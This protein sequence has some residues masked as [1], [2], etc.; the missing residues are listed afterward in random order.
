MI[1]EQFYTKCLAQGAYYIESAG[2]AAIIDPLRE[3]YT[4]LER[5]KQ[6]NTSL[7]YIFETHFHADFVSGHLEL[8]SITKAPIVYGEVANPNFEVIKATDEQIFSI[9]KI[10]IKVLFTPGHTLESCCYLLIN[11]EDK[12]YCVFTGDTLFIGDVGRP[13]LAQK[14][15]EITSEMLAGKLYDSLRN[16]LMTLPDDVI[17]YP[18]HGAGSA[19]GKNMSTETSSTIGVQ[20]KLNYAFNPNLTKSEFIEAVLH[21]LNA[22]P[23]YFKMN[24]DLNKNGYEFVDKLLATNKIPLSAS[25]F[26]Q[27]SLDQNIIILDTRDGEEFAQSHIPNSINIGING[28]FAPW[29]GTI[30]IDVNTPLLLVGKEDM[31]DEVII[32]LSRVG[33]DNVLGYLEGGIAAW[34]DAGFQISSISRNNP[35]FL[36]ENDLNNYQILDVRKKTEFDVGHLNKS[37][38]VPLADIQKWKNTL[39]KNKS[40]IVHCAGGYRSMLASSILQQNGYHIGSEIRGGF[41]A[42]SEQFPNNNLIVKEL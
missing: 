11:E 29:V 18:A 24:V 32:R 20:K 39:D 2:E 19:C 41:K 31:I 13:D 14:G 33:F 15:V 30:L 7:K 37:I 4:Y 26:K 12:P 28:D 27:K 16:K 10:K 35:S 1:V 34:I 3:P 5:L 9:G 42:I 8:S 17:V 36:W 23:S 25:D 22:P 21:G 38:N 40:Y 6:S